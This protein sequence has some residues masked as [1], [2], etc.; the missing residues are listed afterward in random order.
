MKQNSIIAYNIPAVTCPLL[1]VKLEIEAAEPSDSSTTLVLER[2]LVIDQVVERICECAPDG[3]PDC[4]EHSSEKRTTVLLIFFVPIP[5]QVPSFFKKENS[6][7][8]AIYWTV[9][10]GRSR[11]FICTEEEI[12][13]LF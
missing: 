6:G 8:N 1:R 2:T 9:S 10:L 4:F 11:S 5:P 13:S 12:L 3:T 7:E